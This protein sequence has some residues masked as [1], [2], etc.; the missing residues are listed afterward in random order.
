MVQVTFRQKQK[1]FHTTMV[2]VKGCE[3]E[4]ARVKEA[5]L[6]LMEHLC[7]SGTVPGMYGNQ[8][9]HRSPIMTDCSTKGWCSSTTEFQG[10]IAIVLF[11]DLLPTP[12]YPCRHS[13]SH[14]PFCRTHCFET[15][16]ISATSAIDGAVRIPLGPYPITATFG[17]T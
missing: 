9:C 2:V 5:P 6:L 1:N 16:S 15:E 12:S 10:M 14:Y 3:W 11:H 8:A 17:F 13:D 7:G 4:A